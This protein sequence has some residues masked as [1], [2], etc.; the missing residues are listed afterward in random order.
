MSETI[1]GGC[2]WDDLRQA[3]QWAAFSCDSAWNVD[4]NDIYNYNGFLQEKVKN[5]VA[6]EIA[7]HEFSRKHNID[8]T[9]LTGNRIILE[10]VPE[11]D[12]LANKLK[13]DY[14]KNYPKTGKIRRAL[15]YNDRF[16]LNE[17]KPKLTNSLKKL[18]IKLQAT[19]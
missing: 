15:I 14:K 9:T 18:F 3:T 16:A 19:I 13:T 7:M 8:P 12:F 4:K 11:N 2:L 5:P 17:I 1:I 10:R 6:A